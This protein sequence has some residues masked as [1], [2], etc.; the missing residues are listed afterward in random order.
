MS[1][2]SKG[3]PTAPNPAAETDEAVDPAAFVRQR[4]DQQILILSITGARCAGC[5]GKIE[6]AISALPGVSHARLNL[7]TGTM[8]V[9]WIGATNPSLFT[10]TIADLGYGALPFDPQT[11]DDDDGRRGRMLLRCMAVAGFA[12]ANIMLLSVA[13]WSASSTDMGTS[14]RRFLHLVSALIAIPTVFYAGRPFFESALGALR[15]KQANM[16]V[17]ISL[18]VMLALTV[19]LMEALSGGEHAYFDAA[20]MLLFFLLIGRWLDEQLRRRAR[21]AAR[22]LLALQARTAL[23]LDADGSLAP[24]RATEICPGDRLVIRASARVPVDGIV[25]EGRSDTDVAFLTGESAPQLAV[26]GSA[27][28]AG[29]L[30]ISQ[31]LVIEATRDMAHS[32]VAELVRLVEAGQQ[33]KDRYTRLAD[34]AAR[35]YVP[36]VHSLAALTFIGWLM[37]GAGLREAMMAATAVL[38]ITC[39]CALGLAVPAV[40]IVA[41]G[42]LFRRGIIVKSGDALERLARTKHIAFDKTG[43]LTTGAMQWISPGA[44]PPDQADAAAALVRAG[45]HPIARAMASTFGVGPVADDIVEIPGEGMRGIWK[46]DEVRLGKAAFVGVSEAD[47]VPGQ[48][49]RAYLKVGSAAPIELHFSDSLRDGASTTIKTLRDRGLSISLLSGD[50]PAEVQAIA[51]AL[52]IDDVYWSQTPQDKVAMID[53]WQRQAPV[54]MIGDGLNDTAALAHADVSLA[55]GTAADAAQTE[56]D[57]V[58][59]GDGLQAVLSAYETSVEARRHMLQNFAFAALYNAVAAPLAMAGMV[60]PLIA[61][62]AM[63]GSSLLVTLN[64]MRM[65]WRWKAAP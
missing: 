10:Q 50:Q 27:I 20:V 51:R 23:R 43:T 38:V 44:L 29:T 42:R 34:R 32:A 62:L 55:P 17:P 2:T 1:Q 36:I 19:S 64:A 26:Q 41:T 33:V 56:A 63:S 49:S 15:R 58:Y 28:L 9:E 11:A 45:F 22:D 40:Q 54:A 39:P 12:A 30:N 5:I 35:A 53:I 61:A 21:S 16:D 18:A 52:N 13:V 37:T 3:C 14:T 47:H 7:S 24:I 25:L 57:F 31:K 4:D 6:R 48:G 46:G 60:T 59:Q 8:T 65:N